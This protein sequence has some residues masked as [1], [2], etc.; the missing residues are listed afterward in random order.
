[1]RFERG[2]VRADRRLMR[3]V[4]ADEDAVPL[5]AAGLRRLDQH[6]H[7]AVVHVSSEAA[8]H[9]FGEE[10]GVSLERFEDPLVIEDSRC[11]ISSYR[12]GVKM[13]CIVRI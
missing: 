13:S 11:H 4:G 6:E 7:L 9:P 1:V 2:E 12:F 3:E 5:P 8:E 10:G